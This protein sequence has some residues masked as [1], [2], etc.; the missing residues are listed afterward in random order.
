M[1]SGAGS[2][3]AQSIGTLVLAVKLTTSRGGLS[4]LS[5]ATSANR[6]DLQGCHLPLV[7]TPELTQEML[8]EE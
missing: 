8:E 4:L 7:L 6:R 5:P 2:S 1:F 3:S